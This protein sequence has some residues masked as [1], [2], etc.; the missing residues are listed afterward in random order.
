[1][2]SLDGA[3][4]FTSGVDPEDHAV[5]IE[6]WQAQNDIECQTI[7]SENALW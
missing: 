3:A 1:M 2:A 5:T 4:S 6:R 7:F